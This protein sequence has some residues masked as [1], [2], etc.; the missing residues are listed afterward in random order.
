[1]L[2]NSKFENN[3]TRITLVQ[4]KSTFGQNITMK[5]KFD[6]SCTKNINHAKI[7]LDK[8]LP[9]FGMH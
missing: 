1:M 9:S 7:S 8:S 6:E 3:V 5:T 2:V 4:N